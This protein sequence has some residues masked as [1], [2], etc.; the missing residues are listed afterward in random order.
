M[1][2]TEAA[3]KWLQDNGYGSDEIRELGLEPHELEILGEAS[4]TSIKRIEIE[5]D[6]RQRIPDVVWKA[7]LEA[8]MNANDGDKTMAQLLPILL[9]A[10]RTGSK[11]Y[12]MGAI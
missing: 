5:L 11:I 10:L 12:T 9:T 3:L 1:S 6:T 8:A 7:A 4:G 2:K